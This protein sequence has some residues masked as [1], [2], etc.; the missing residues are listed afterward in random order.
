MLL[1]LAIE[2]SAFYDY[3]TKL[4]KN[5]SYVGMVNTNNYRLKSFKRNASYLKRKGIEAS[6]IGYQEASQYPSNE[7]LKKPLRWFTLQAMLQG[8][9]PKDSVW[10]HT[11]YQKE[12]A[13]AELDI[14]KGKFLSGYTAIKQMYSRYH[15]FFDTKELK[16]KQ[17][18]IRKLKGY[19]REKRLQNKYTLQENELR[20][21]YTILMDEDIAFKE[22]KNLGWWESQIAELDTIFK[23]ND[24][25]YARDMVLRT[26]GYLKALADNYK[27]NLLDKK[28]N[29]E[30]KMF[31]NILRFQR[32]R[33]SL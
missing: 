23:K 7:L 4:K 16:E 25:V 9:I 12:L 29:F 31:L 6:I 24:N 17:A 13:K 1:E 30:K 28:K 15:L 21:S 22:Y 26:K 27:T 5:F 8:R 3:K 20:N 32:Y 33:S 10:V 2:N 19:K 11:E 14:K 18:E